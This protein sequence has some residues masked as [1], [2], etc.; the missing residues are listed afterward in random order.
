MQEVSPDQVKAVQTAQ[1]T[2]VQKDVPQEQ[3]IFFAA[4][5]PNTPLAD[6]RVRQALNYGVDV[7]SIIQNVLQGYARRL[8]NP[9]GPLSLG[10]D[11]NVKPYSYNL[12]KAKALLAE[13]GYANGFDVVIDETNTA[14]TA[15]IEA[16]VGELAKLNVRATIRQLDL[17]TFNDN[18]GKKQTSPLI[19]ASW[20]GMFDPS[21]A[22]SFWGKSNGFLSRYK[23]AEADTLIAA[24]AG[25][26][27]PVKRTQTYAQ[28]S[29]LLNDDPLALYLWSTQNLYGVGKRVVGWQAHP[30]SYIVV[31]NVAVK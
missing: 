26:L 24:G 1:L 30:R 5:A 23:N 20:S 31:S 29:K 8:S 7:D 25:T 14:R 4:D 16:V 22:L 2:L 13:A 28:L 19:A 11:A 6:K 12:V 9:I 21:N 18:W 17:G 10:Y 27:D 3:F 15:P